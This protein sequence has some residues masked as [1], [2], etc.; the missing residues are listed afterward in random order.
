MEIPRKATPFD[1]NGFYTHLWKFSI[2][3]QWN[4]WNELVL[5]T[6]PTRRP[7]NVIMTTTTSTM[8]IA[9]VLNNSI[10]ELLSLQES[11]PVHLEH[12]L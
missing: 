4:D 5:N 11:E 8:Y 6:G 3:S 9:T 7:S 12:W 1:C 10:I 2:V